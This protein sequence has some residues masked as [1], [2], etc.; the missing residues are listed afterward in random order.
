[1]RKGQT[2]IIGFMVIIL[3][4]FFGLIFYF[5]FSSSSHTTIISDTEQSLE[6]S[7]L[8]TVM[9]QYTLCKDTS[10]GDAIKSCAGGGGF[11]CDADACTTVKNNVAQIASL[12]GWDTTSYMF[13]IGDV[14]YSPGTCTGN[15]LVESYTT[16]NVDVKLI[17]CTS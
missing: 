11:V 3:L 5:I 16:V 15:T 1:M 2:E 4:L 12:N 17:Y 13:Y 8:L 7:N 14:L 9:K 10:L 6:V